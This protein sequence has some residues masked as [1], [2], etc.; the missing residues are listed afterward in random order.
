MPFRQSKPKVC[1]FCLQ[2]VEYVDYKDLQT[3]RSYLNER[4]KIKA[5]R[6]SGACPQ[7]QRQ[8]SAAV[9]NARDMSL[10]AYTAR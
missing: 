4:G 9:K 3:L 5:G 8:L 6:T 10:I 7:H 1:Q 2:K